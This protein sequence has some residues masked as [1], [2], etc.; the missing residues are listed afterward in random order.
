MQRSA[1]A[2]HLGGIQST[3][4]SEAVYVRSHVKKSKPEGGDRTL[5]ARG[6]EGGECSRRERRGNSRQQLIRT[7]SE[8]FVCSRHLLIASR[9]ADQASNQC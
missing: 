3:R 1:E 9:P 6:D 7:K 2:L 8:L 5:T 4:A